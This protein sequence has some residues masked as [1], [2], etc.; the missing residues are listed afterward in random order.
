MEEFIKTI[1]A[2]VSCI[3][4]LAALIRSGTGSSA[5]EAREMGMIQQKLDS[6]SN[7]IQEI[8]AQNAVTAKLETQLEEKVKTL[9]VWKESVERRLLNME[10]KDN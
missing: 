7:D 10:G 9:L 2:I 3:V 4:A 5:A 8:K 6:I 1:P